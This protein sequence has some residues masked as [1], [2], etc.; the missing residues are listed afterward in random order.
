MHPWLL[1][2]SLCLCV[3][4]VNFLM[5][6]LSIANSIVESITEALAD[7]EPDATVQTVHVRVGAMSGVVPDALDFAWSSAA[8]GTRLDGAIL[9]IDFV[10]AA[11]FCPSCNTEVE[12]PGPIMRCP[13]CGSPTPKLV[14]GNELEILSVELNDDP[15]SPEQAAHP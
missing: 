1:F 3:S 11:V 14:R 6:E 9:D 2:A 4:V 10:P 15:T 8:M 13:D 12:L 5:H 7:S